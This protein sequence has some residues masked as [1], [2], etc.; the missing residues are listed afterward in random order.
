MYVAITSPWAIRS[1]NWKMANGSF[2]TLGNLGYPNHR[3]KSPYFSRNR[4]VGFQ[5]V[6]H[7]NIQYSTGSGMAAS[8]MR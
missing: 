2:D 3:R 6:E 1:S 7:A 8:M 5:A 4:A